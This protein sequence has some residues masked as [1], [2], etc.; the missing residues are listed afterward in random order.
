[1]FWGWLLFV[2]L[3]FGYSTKCNIILARHQCNNIAV[4]T[5]NVDTSAKCNTVLHDNTCTKFNNNDLFDPG[6]GVKYSTIDITVLLLWYYPSYGT[7][8]DSR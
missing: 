6:N 2:T 3:S 8:W 1:M 4:T 7:K 5:T